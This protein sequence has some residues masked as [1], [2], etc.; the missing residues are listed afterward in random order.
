MIGKISNIRFKRPQSLGFFILLAG[1]IISLVSFTVCYVVTSTI[2][3]SILET[4]AKNLNS[5]VSNQAIKSMILLMKKG[6]SK[7]ELL[8][9]LKTLKG[10]DGKEIPPYE[11]TI[12]RA[13]IVKDIFGDISNE[14]LSPEAMD[15]LEKGITINSRD[16][17]IIKNAYPIKA[18]QYCLKCH[19]NAKVGTVLGAIQVS[20]NIGILQHN[21][22][23]MFLKFFIILSPLPFLM[24]F[25]ISLFF[26]GRINIAARSFKRR[27][28]AI[29]SIKDL[30]KLEIENLEL[31]FL[32]FN[33]IL[34]DIKLFL[35][36]MKTV[37]VDKNML[38]FEIKVLEKFIITSEVVRDWKKHV[39]GLLLEINE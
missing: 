31:G 5:V 9:F 4:S 26:T 13:S 30:T 8:E 33:Q 2:Y 6:W 34:H 16:G 25:L 17:Y 35:D 32:E 20:Q 15:A 39:S 3:S 11:I 36:K 27:I 1:L 7:G 19:V 12:Y 21:A 37:A 14:K 10:G 18:E 22:N 24:A 28:E 38:E 29:N 23:K